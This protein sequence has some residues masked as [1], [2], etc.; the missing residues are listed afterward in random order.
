MPKKCQH[1]FFDL[2]T[3]LH[4][5]TNSLH[6]FFPTHL[7]RVNNFNIYFVTLVILWIIPKKTIHCKPIRIA[8]C[9]SSNN[10]W[11]RRFQKIRF[12]DQWQTD[13]YDPDKKRFQIFGRPHLFD[14]PNNYF[15]FVF[16]YNSKPVFCSNL[17]LH[18]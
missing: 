1:N 16:H 4:F 10:P 7:E 9:G 14:F 2:F 8:Q 17:F 6:S 12:S 15:I 3:L 13:P 18:I 5:K 11:I